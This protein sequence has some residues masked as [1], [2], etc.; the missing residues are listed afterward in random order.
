MSERLK[1]A[2]YHNLPSGG[3]SRTVLETTRRLAERHRVDLFTTSQADRRF[4][5]V[6]PFVVN[7]T[8]YDYRPLPL[9]RRPFGRLNPAMRLLSVF[10]I[11]ALGRRAAAAIDRIGYDVVLVHPCQVTQ[12]P[13]VLRYTRTPSVYYCQE[14]LR[15]LYEPPIPRPYDRES[16]IRQGLDRIDPLR[17]ANRLVAGRIDRRNLRSASLVLT[18]SHFTRESIRRIYGV[19]ARVSRLGVDAHRFQ[20]VE[21]PKEPFVLSVGALTPAKGFDFLIE[22]IGAIPIDRRPPLAIVSNAVIAEERLFLQNLATNV[23][24]DVLFRVGVPHEDIIR[25][26]STARLTVYA[27]IR[28]PLGLVPLESQSCGTAVVAVAEGGVKETIQP[29]R[30]GVLVDRDPRRFG[31][32]IDSLLGT[33]ESRDRYGRAGRRWVE[34]QWTWEGAVADIE[35]SLLAVAG[36]RP[37]QDPTPPFVPSGDHRGGDR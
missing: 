36:R 26:Y 2:L 15:S 35:R 37:G 23:G 29:D 11:D 27:P 3:G 17:H 6:S 24:V 31:D 8:V 20:P 13:S 25:M 16:E 28:E 5:D 33:D 9:L 4:C 12:A 34:E 19:D 7:S 30:T 18:N 32:A 14:P 21:A 1:I 22:S 10:L